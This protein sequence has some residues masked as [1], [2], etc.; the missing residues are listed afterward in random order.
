MKKLLLILILTLSF[1]SWVNAGDIKDFE[2]EGISIGDS[3]LKHFTKDLIKKNSF[4]Y[5][6]DKKFTPV[7]MPTLTFYKQYDYIDFDFKTNDKRY[8]IHALYGV[9]SYERNINDCYKQMDEIVVSMNKLFDNVEV[10]E[11]YE[12]KRPGITGDPL[13]KSK[14]TIVNFWFDNGDRASVTCYD[15]SKEHGGRDN[16]TVGIQTKEQNDFLF[17]KAYK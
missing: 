1:H 2:I 11:R 16:L 12:E 8:F 9:I 4:D 6:N 5:Y 10:G 13:G 7:Q 3:A 14:A 17:N 15:Y